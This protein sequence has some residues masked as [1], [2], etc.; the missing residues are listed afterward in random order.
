MTDA[1]TFT[2]PFWVIPAVLTVVIWTAAIYWPKGES[3]G[4][5]PFGEAL[6][7]TFHIALGIIATLVVWLIF[8]M[9][10]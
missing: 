10:F 1:M 3:H 5:Y 7:A 9:V 2:L 6:V 4:G 8:F